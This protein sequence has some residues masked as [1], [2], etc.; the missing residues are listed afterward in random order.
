MLFCDFALCS[1]ND[2]VVGARLVISTAWYEDEI[3]S[4]ETRPMATSSALRMYRVRY[5]LVEYEPVHRT[6]S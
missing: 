4:Y 1:N 6:R 3:F 2:L 5:L